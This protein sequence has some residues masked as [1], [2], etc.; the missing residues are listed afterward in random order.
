MSLSNRIEE[1]FKGIVEELGYE[2]IYVE[3]VKEGSEWYLRYFI[4]SPNG[5]GINDCE[6]VSKHVEVILDEKEYIDGQYIL[7]VSS[8][9]LEK[10]LR[11][12]EDFFDNIGNLIEVHLYKGIDKKKNFIGKLRGYGDVLLLDVKGKIIEIPKENISKANLSVEM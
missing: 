10:P 7:E 1:D 12:E 3:Y 4:D 5:I 6:K 2:L 8:L 11:C 9:G